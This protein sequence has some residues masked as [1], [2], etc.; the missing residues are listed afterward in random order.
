MPCSAEAKRRFESN[1]IKK[2]TG[3]GRKKYRDFIPVT[4]LAFNIELTGRSGRNARSNPR[5]R[6]GGLIGRVVRGGPK[7]EY[8]R[9]SQQRRTEPQAARLNGCRGGPVCAAAS[10]GAGRG[11]N[12]WRGRRGTKGVI[13]IIRRIKLK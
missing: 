11:Q 9:V 1:K 10:N 8:S 6:P 2:I 5:S 12:Y 3:L 7:R 4:I 13:I